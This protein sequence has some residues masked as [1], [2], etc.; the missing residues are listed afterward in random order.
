MRRASLAAL[1]V[2]SGCVP[3]RAG[4]PAD[5][6]ATPE[7]RR[8]VW[9]AVQPMAAM[10][11][12]DP[13]FVYALVGL[14][15]G[16]DPH[17]RSGEARGLLQIRPEAWRAVSD[18]PYE[19]AVWDWRTNLAVGIGRLA[20]AKADLEAQRVFSYPLLWAAHHY[21]IDYVASRG[22][23]ISRIPRPSDPIARALWSGETHPV[24]PPK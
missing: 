21:G 9:A 4:A 14:E 15:S 1:L 22:F 8:Q 20:S 24:N 18:I 17:A 7:M 11:G 5:P 16:F 13:L 6:R 2:L 23:D 12:I 10:R 19:A 3:H